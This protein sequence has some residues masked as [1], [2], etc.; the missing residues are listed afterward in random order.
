ML[1]REAQISHSAPLE[2]E[3]G[4]VVGRIPSACPETS[5]FSSQREDFLQARAGD[6]DALARILAAHRA[7]VRAVLLGYCRLDEVDDLVQ[8]V[9]IRAITHLDQLRDDALVGPWLAAIARSQAQG[10]KRS[11]ARRWRNLRRYQD[12]VA[13]ALPLPSPDPAASL[14]AAEV[15]AA[16]RKL[17]EEYRDILIMR[18]VEQ[19]TGP[20]IAAWTGRSHAAIRVALHRGMALLRLQCGMENNP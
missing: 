16:I 20:Q 17:P 18:L 9:F 6:I 8:D 15:L 10:W 12:H 1:I 7:M 14:Q 5:C 2:L 13:T 19:F 4:D 11:L 3:R